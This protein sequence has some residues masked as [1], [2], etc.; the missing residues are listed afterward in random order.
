M[1]NPNENSASGVWRLR[2]VYRALPA[3]KWPTVYTAPNTSTYA[4]LDPNK[5]SGLTLSNN[6]LTFYS[7]GSNRDTCMATQSL[8][9]GKWYWELEV[10]KYRIVVGIEPEG[11]T[12]PPGERVGEDSPGYSWRIDLSKKCHDASR[13]SGYGASVSSGDIVGTALD[14]ENGTLEYFLN[15]VSQGVAFSNITGSWVPAVGDSAN[16]GE[17]EGTVNF[18]Q[19]P[20]A[21]QPPNGFSSVG[22]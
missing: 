15:G 4:T 6:N 18:G 17:A 11:Y 13:V 1:A 7:D 5:N 21:F 10:I 3:D 20:F 9:S 14:L 16:I 12:P 2:D 8:S 19:N 22:T